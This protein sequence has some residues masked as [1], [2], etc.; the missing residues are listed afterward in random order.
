MLMWRSRYSFNYTFIVDTQWRVVP[1]KKALNND[2][3]PLHECSADNLYMCL[4]EEKLNKRNKDTIYM[5]VLP[6]NM[7]NTSSDNN[8]YRCGF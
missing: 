5:F 8:T 1:W 3:L 4:R 7:Q 2:P 6:A